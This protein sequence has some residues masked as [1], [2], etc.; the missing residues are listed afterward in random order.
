M[1]RISVIIP[2][3]NVR[4]TVLACIRSIEAQTYREIEIIAV[5]DGSDDGTGALLDDYA[6]GHTGIKIIHK[7]NGGVSSARNAGLQVAT[8][9]YIGFVDS[10]DWVEPDMFELLVKAMKD[11]NAQLASCDLFCEYH[12]TV[13]YTNYSGNCNVVPEIAEVKNPYRDIIAVPQ[14]S[15]YLWNKLFEKEFVTQ[16]SMNEQI[17]QNEDL[18]FVTQYLGR[19]N[20]MVHVNKKLYH[21]RMGNVEPQTA[22]TKRV[23]TLADAYEQI[24]RCY[25]E[26]APDWAWLPEKNL[27][28]IFL[29]FKGRMK[30]QAYKDETFRQQTESGIKKH[31]KPILSSR[32]VS[33]AEKIN[34]ILTLFFPGV[35]LR[36]K[37]KVLD[38]RHKKGQWEE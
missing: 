6:A 27:L 36:I 10:D 29:N 37:N 11:Y 22:I 9:E 32:D 30:L 26:K 7:P 3:C 18:L 35:I 19:V 38:G 24:L 5:D 2:A 13:P 14:I 21:Y 25:C 12:D 8:G 17:A 33:L 23:L 4:D 20:K 16:L 34:I 15:G 1:S 28:K 31:L